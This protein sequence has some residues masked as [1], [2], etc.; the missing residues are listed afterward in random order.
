MI[1]TFYSYKGGVGR[2]MALANVAKLLHDSD[3][4]VI[5]IDWDLE[6]PGLEKFFFRERK[7]NEVQNEPGIIKFLDEVQNKPGIIELIQDFKN[8]MSEELII[9]D[10][11]KLPFETPANFAIGIPGYN[12]IKLIPP[13]NRSQIRDYTESVLKFNM[14]DFYNHWEGELYFEWLRQELQS[15]ADIVLIDCRTGVSEMGNVC[16]NLLADIVVMFCAPNDQNIKGTKSMADAFTHEKI[17][18]LRHGRKLNLII[19]PSRVDSSEEGQ[20]KNFINDFRD[21]FS[22]FVPKELCGGEPTIAPFWNLKIPYVAYYSFREPL[23][24]DDVVL[25]SKPLYDSYFALAREIG[26]LGSLLELFPKENDEPIPRILDLLEEASWGSMKSINTNLKRYNVA[27]EELVHRAKNSIYAICIFPPD[28]IINGPYLFNWDGLI[29]R[30]DEKTRLVK[31]VN[32]LLN[33]DNYIYVDNVS[34]V[35]SKKNIIEARK[36]E[37]PDGLLFSLSLQDDCVILSSDYFKK[38]NE[39]V[40]LYRGG[41]NS[42]G[43]SNI[44]SRNYKETDYYKNFWDKVVESGT[45]ID[46][47]RILVTG[48]YG[49][50]EDWLRN[51]DSINKFISEYNNGVKLG[52]CSIKNDIIASRY[53]GDLVIIDKEIALKYEPN[54]TESNGV[55]YGRLQYIIGDIVNRYIRLFD[56]ESSIVADLEK[57][58]DYWKWWNNH[59]NADRND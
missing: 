59:D 36:K 18:E 33:K 5:V 54:Q 15:S 39:E 9:S 1:C 19:V 6:A 35:F 23:A 43:E 47:R 55:R 51:K 28:Y 10:D 12:N 20:L 41:K 14:D 49:N 42:E 58:D 21:A 13:G 22:C 2:T 7:S 4:K 46:K 27:C 16:A 40:R 37:G 3:L 32:G 45:D 8:K 25:I 53:H 38:G 11:G 31:Y 52:I 34:F 56:V 57:P 24:V 17:K 44:Y 48:I 30:Y 29:D 26:R 50:D